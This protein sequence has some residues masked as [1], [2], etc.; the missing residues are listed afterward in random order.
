MPPAHLLPPRGIHDGSGDVPVG[1]FFSQHRV[2]PIVG[3]DELAIGPLNNS[4]IANVVGGSVAHPQ[5]YLM[6]PGSA[7]IGTHSQ[8]DPGAILASERIGQRKPAITH[9]DERR[10]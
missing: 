4:R 5:R 1:F 2:V 8:A 7:S 3:D 10:R 6:T 9:L